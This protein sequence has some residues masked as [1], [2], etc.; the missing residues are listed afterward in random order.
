MP[1]KAINYNESCIYT[2]Q[3]KGVI[4]YVGSTTNFTN[5]KWSHKSICNNINSVAYEYDIYKFIRNNEGWDA[6]KMVLI[7]YYKCNNGI[8]LCAREQ[9]W[10]N[11]YKPNLLN[12]HCSERSKEQWRL[13]NIEHIKE[14]KI[15]NRD[16][17]KAYQQTYDKQ[18]R[19]RLKEEKRIAK[20]IYQEEHRDEILAEKKKKLDA[21]IERKKIYKAEWHQRKKNEL[22]TKQ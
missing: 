18:R 6:W 16:R 3:Y 17:L 4:Y 11:E 1:R 20:E 8:E 14:Y 7:E 13:D 10:I 19:I 5:R 21:Q 22:N 12:Y 2:L 15:E 9:H